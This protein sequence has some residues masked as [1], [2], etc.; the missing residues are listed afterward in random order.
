MWPHSVVTKSS[1]EPIGVRTS[2][3]TCFA[4]V[5]VAAM[6]LGGCATG[7][8][9]RSQPSSSSSSGPYT[10][11]GNV[12]GLTGTGLV[13]QDNGKDNLTINAN[14]P[15]TFATAVASGYLVT[16]LTQPTNP[17]QTCSVTNGTGTTT[18]NVT[19]VEIVCGDIFTVGGSI[20][21]LDGSGLVLQDN[22]G[23]NLHVSGTGNVSFTFA[24]P[25]VPGTAYAVTVLTQ[26]SNPTQTCTVSN[27]TGTI[28]GNVTNVLLSC[29]QPKFTIGGSVVGLIQGVGD[30]LELQDNGGDNLLVTGDANF[31]FPTLVTYGGIYN[32]QVFLPPS[33]QPQPCNEFFY[34]GVATGNVSDVIVDC[35][36]NDWNWISWYIS[37][38]NTANNLAAVTTP[39]FPPGEIAPPDVGTPG[40][41]VF[42][43]TW[44]DAQ[45]NKWLFGGNGYPFPNPLVPTSETLPGLL[46]DLWVYDQAIGG[47][48]P[49]NLPTFINTSGYWQ[50]DTTP[51]ES[52]DASGY[53]GTL[54][55]STGGTP[56]ARWGSSTWTDGS[57]NLW[58]FGGQGYDSSTEDFTLLNDIWEWIPGGLDPN[59]AGT[60]TGEWIWQGGSSVGSSA[61]NNGAPANY[62]TQNVPAAGNIPGGRW[63]AA[64][65]TD[66]AGANVWLFGGQ[67][68]DSTGTIVL[69][70]DLWEYNIASR[71]WTWIS[72]SNVGNKNG[73][74]GTQGSPAAGNFPG[75]RQ[76]AV[77]WVDASG[78]VWLFGGFGFDSVGSGAP[79]GDTLNDLWEFSGGQ[80]TWVSGSNLA[81][82][83]GTYGTQTLPA[84]AN[85]PGSRWG[86]G[87]WTDASNNLWFFGGWGYGSITSHPQGYLNDIWEYQHSTGQWIWWKGS[88][89]VNQN[90]QYLTNG[91]PY[92]KN[93]VGAR[94]GAGIWVPDA[95]ACPVTGAVGNGGACYVW[96]FGGAGYDN[97][98]NT[99]P[100]YLNDLWTYLPFP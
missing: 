34:T 22:G 69:L 88:N 21:G 66:A 16:V 5:V 7:F 47:W 45:G 13:L 75:G 76:N 26:P 64:T 92:V 83:N 73:V 14:G 33:S 30:T 95:P 78:K 27:G 12:L 81:N 58:M 49:A 57:G 15:F 52:E 31:T 85:V 9:W 67:G 74:Y 97:S 44:T 37:S 38:T 68:V 82:Q 94:R 70:N 8:N 39:L 40:G 63:A 6:L 36:H 100:G 48:L 60:F 18:A 86:S 50:D 59:G 53:Y 32:V 89:D 54:G 1:Y 42:P 2:S 91:I 41:R 28:S 99:S 56:G 29:S 35:Q 51:L 11:G 62:G 61:T 10:I 25:L 96:V 87:G 46:N 43:A 84:A 90:G 19:N 80:W 65:F 71:T 55:A 98:Q 3:W 20:T 93:V 24:T 17:T 4:A 77:L 23:D 79:L 72:G